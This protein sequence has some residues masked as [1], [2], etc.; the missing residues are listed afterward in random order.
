M[1]RMLAF[2]SEEPILIRY[3]V[4]EISRSLHWMSRSGRKAP[5][6][7]GFGLAYKNAEGRMTLRTWGREELPSLEARQF[8]EM[9]GIKTTLFLGH[10][11]QASEG[12]QKMTAAEAHPFVKGSVYLA[13]NGT[14]RDA[15]ALDTEEGTDTQRLLRWISLH[16]EPRSF[17]GLQE[18]LRLLLTEVKDYTAINLLITE[19]THVYAFCCYSEEPEQ[20]ALHYRLDGNLAIVASEPLDGGSWQ[21]LESRELLQISPSMMLQKVRVV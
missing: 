4:W 1:C 16:W 19:G 8:A 13:H 18:A 14:I 12:Y 5:H 17:F 2:I 10:A 20:Y 9:A 15:D 21:K 11:R 3:Y 7:D 6:R